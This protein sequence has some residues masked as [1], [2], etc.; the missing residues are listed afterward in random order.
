MYGFFLSLSL[1]LSLSTS[2]PQIIT[3][4]TGE[5]TCGITGEPHTV[6]IKTPLSTACGDTKGDDCGTTSTCIETSN[7]TAG[8]CTCSSGAMNP[9]LCTHYASYARVESVKNVMLRIMLSFYINDTTGRVELH[10]WEV[11]CCTFVVATIL[12]AFFFNCICCIRSKIEADRVR[13]EFNA[14]DHYYSELDDECLSSPP[15]EY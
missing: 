10:T 14:M 12:T 1:S 4:K 15:S 13:N 3:V 2:T 8:T 5:D 11:I 7:S 9:P 6:T